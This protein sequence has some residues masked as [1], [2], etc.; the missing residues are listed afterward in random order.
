MSVPVQFTVLII[1]ICAR[2]HFEQTKKK[3]FKNSKRRETLKTT[4]FHC[5]TNKKE[6]Q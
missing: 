5:E 6:P 3:Y 1:Y 2:F 4:K